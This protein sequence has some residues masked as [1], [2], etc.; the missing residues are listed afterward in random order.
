MSERVRQLNEELAKVP[1]PA[2]HER[3]IKFNEN[4]VSLVV[5]PPDYP[6]S[7]EE[8]GRGDARAPAQENSDATT[9]AV[10]KASGD[11]TTTTATTT[12]E[13]TNEIEA[14]EDQS[15]RSDRDVVA[16]TDNERAQEPEAVVARKDDSNETVQESNSLTS[17]DTLATDDSASGSAATSAQ[18]SA[19][20]DEEQVLVEHN[21]EFE[22]VKVSS[23]TAEERE[24]YLQN[25]SSPSKAESH[26]SKTSVDSGSSTSNSQRPPR[27]KSSFRPTR[28]LTAS[29]GSQQERNQMRHKRA[30]SAQATRRQ[31]R[32]AVRDDAPMSD[33]G[34]TSPYALTEEQKLIGEKQ[35]RKQEENK[36]KREE[37]E[38]KKKEKGQK[39]MEYLASSRKLIQ[40]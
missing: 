10:P 26:S 12:T 18:A 5:P 30:H 20:A 4:P 28:P 17:Q 32:E 1:S 16:D 7:D 11:M 19:A 34:Y 3:S 8:E 2:E 27:P 29:S 22:L 14:G 6:G 15:E 9:D 23:L 36:R 35:R 13:S 24:L 21:G 38:R 33:F 31:D 40:G 37:E 25:N 39:V